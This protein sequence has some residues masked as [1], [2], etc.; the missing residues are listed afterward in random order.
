MRRDNS[1]KIKDIKR[2]LMLYNVK[3]ARKIIFDLLENQNR[4]SLL[5]HLLAISYINERD[6]D[7]AVF[8]LESES[9]VRDKILNR[10]LMS[11]YIKLD[12]MVDVNKLYLNYFRDID[13]DSDIMKYSVKDRQLL[14][15]LKTLFDDNYKIGNREMFIIK[16]LN[17]YSKDSVIKKI[18]KEHSDDDNNRSIFKGQDIALLYDKVS[19]YVEKNPEDAILS[20]PIF[21]EY[22][23]YL[24]NCG[25]CD[26]QDTNYFR[27]V[28][29]VNTSKIIT[30]HPILYSR[31]CSYNELEA[32]DNN[33]ED[34]TNVGHVKVKTGLERF[35]V[36]Y[37]K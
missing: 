17:K 27:A 3:D 12:Q 30:M 19:D 9:T 37:S 26:G 29:I 32:K 24:N 16:M 33:S 4:D 6:Y 8:L 5:L 28:T 22:C 36:R 1:L 7:N 15:Y 35:N 23:F 31:Y 34:I 2:L 10:D 14:I 13:I 25:I 20:L 18:L 11:L 21:D